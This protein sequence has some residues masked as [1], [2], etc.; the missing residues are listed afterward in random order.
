MAPRWAWASKR[1]V[2]STSAR[3]IIGSTPRK[4]GASV[5]D[6]WFITVSFHQQR[7]RHFH[8][9]R[10]PEYILSKRDTGAGN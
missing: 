2:R 3:R 10:E 7:R 9:E 8:D 6:R 5:A 1:T 4:R